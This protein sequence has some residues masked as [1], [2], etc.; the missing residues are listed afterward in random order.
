[1]VEIIPAILPKSLEGLEQKL[2]KLLG[3]APLVQIDLVGTNIL[4]G[5]EALPLWEELDFEIDIMLPNPEQEVRTCLD[6][7]A[8]RIVVHAAAPGAAEALQML[9]ATREGHYPVLV[10][11]ALGV[12]ESPEAL[13]PFL[14]MYDYVQVMGIAHIG[15]QGEPFDERSLALV[16][17]LRAAHPELVLQVDGAAATHPRELAEAGANRLVVGSAIINAED[18]HAV[19]KELY[20]KANAL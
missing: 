10:G 17:A 8:S 13:V 3:V 5:Q 19:Y 4:V 12:E 15:K 2:P 6:I 11:V 20:T 1:M 16:R 18:P 7:G 14:G 9:Q